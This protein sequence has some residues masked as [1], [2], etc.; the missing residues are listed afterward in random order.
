MHLT[1][2]DHTP[3]SR[4]QLYNMTTN[5]TIPTNMR[6]QLNHEFKMC[7]MRRVELETS[8]IQQRFDDLMKCMCWQK[9]IRVEDHDL[10]ASVTCLVRN[11]SGLRDICWENL[12]VQLK[13]LN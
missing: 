9:Y 12:D 10:V 4:T 13:I 7:S 8:G 2:Y 5:Y 11:N 3:T 1:R 6:C